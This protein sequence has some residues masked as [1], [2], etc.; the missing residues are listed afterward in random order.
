ML[1]LDESPVVQ[2]A[3]L[4]NLPIAVA[5]LRRRLDAP[6]YRDIATALLSAEA[7]A[8]TRWR[9]AVGIAHAM[10]AIAAEVCTSS[11]RWPLRRTL[12]GTC[13]APHAPLRRMHLLATYASSS[14]CIQLPCC[15]ALCATTCFLWLHVVTDRCERPLLAP[16]CRRVNAPLQPAFHLPRFH[17]WPRRRYTRL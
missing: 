3:V 11:S 5:R 12:P 6:H 2:L 8:R 14:G 10:R 9:I 4:E 15:I 16:P 17:R 1:L 13:L 7:A